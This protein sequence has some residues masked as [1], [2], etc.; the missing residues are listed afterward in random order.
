MDRCNA[1]RVTT[2]LGTALL[3]CIAPGCGSKPVGRDLT[4]GEGH[5]LQAARL[6]NGFKSEHGG[7]GPA[8]TDELKNWVS[9]LKPE[10]RTQYGVQDVDKALVSPR[11]G[12]PYVVLRP[13]GNQMGY[14]TVLLEKIGV[15]GKH[16]SASN[17]GSVATLSE[18]EFKQA[19]G[20]AR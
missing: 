2:L 17:M 12:E 7:K 20:Y 9:K 19:M 8:N 14:G 15:G 16:L 3:G 4:D 10:K 6:W 11:D 13:T 18:E 5:I 1:F